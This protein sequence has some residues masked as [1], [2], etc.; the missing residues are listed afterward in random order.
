MIN[1]LKIFLGLHVHYF[2][3]WKI[4]SDG[5]LIR[6]DGKCGGL[7]VIQSRAC[8]SCGLREFKEDRIIY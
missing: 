5:K 4:L 7:T 3:K 1:S 8:Q 2:D 6:S